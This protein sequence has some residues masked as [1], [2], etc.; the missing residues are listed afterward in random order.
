MI[1][2][3]ESIKGADERGRREGQKKAKSRKSKRRKAEREKRKE[4]REKREERF[5]SPSR[6]PR[7]VLSSNPP[8]FSPSFFDNLKRNK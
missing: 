8:F 6:S 1:R 4:K 5:S 3:R 2:R 7:L